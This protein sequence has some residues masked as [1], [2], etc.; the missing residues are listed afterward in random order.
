MASLLSLP[1][2]LLAAVVSHV[3]PS[4]AD[5][6]YYPLE[7]IN[8]NTRLY[9]LAQTCR[10][11]RDVCLPKL[12]ETLKFE[13][14]F[15]VDRQVAVLRTL[16]ARPDLAKAVKRITAN[17]SV[18][19]CNETREYTGGD[20]II[21]AADAATFNRALEEKIDDM[22]IVE[23]FHELRQADVETYEDTL[24]SSVAY[25]SFALAH[26][27]TS[28]T[29]CSYYDVLPFFKPGSFPSL[30]TLG[31]KDS[32]TERGA[33]FDDVR[34]VLAVAPNVTQLVGGAVTQLPDET[35]SHPD[36]KKLVLS[37]SRI[38]DAQIQR[39][40]AAFPNLEAFSYTYIGLLGS[41]Y[42]SATPRAMHA[43]LLSMRETLKRVELG[44]CYEAYRMWADFK[45]ARDCV[46]GS[47][48]Q[49]GALESLRIY[50]RYVYPAEEYAAQLPAP[51][52][53]LVDFLP[54]SIKSLYVEDLEPAQQQDV[55]ALAHAAPGQF[56]KLGNVTFA[57]FDKAL[58]DEVRHAFDERGIACSFEMVALHE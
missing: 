21:S 35:T 38:N 2:E 56:P 16:T 9:R 19:L 7:Y 52:M 15:W 12:Y 18:I 6:D 43:V 51:R 11:L 49:M 28:I 29:F 34:G 46:M 22:S 55:L 4:Q 24:G 17:T 36:V 5:I 3:R 14:L 47:F 57:G 30:T 10:A 37:Y 41:D 48:S 26:E 32:D 31:V 25:L 20:P 13:E 39:L 58:R 33:T 27:V 42:S 44:R 50:A 54:P 45:D 1:T 8:N 53:T 23:P 40:P